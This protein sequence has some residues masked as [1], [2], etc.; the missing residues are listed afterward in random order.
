V[1][2]WNFSLA[3]VCFQLDKWET[4]CFVLRVSPVIQVH[5]NIA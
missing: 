4:K 2:D 5:T 3:K 1:W